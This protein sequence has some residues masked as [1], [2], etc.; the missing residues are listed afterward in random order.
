MQK[1][2]TNFRTEN[3][4]RSVKGVRISTTNENIV[5][6]LCRDGDRGDSEWEKETEREAKSRKNRGNENP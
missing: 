3:A 1:S 6:H 4:N 2:A 5:V